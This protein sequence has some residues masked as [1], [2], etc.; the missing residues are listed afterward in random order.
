MIEGRKK[1]SLYRHGT[2]LIEVED[3][4]VKQIHRE[5][6]AH[7]GLAKLPKRLRERVRES[8]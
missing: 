3:G 8:I 7:K 4:F 1:R 2:R 5:F 6:T